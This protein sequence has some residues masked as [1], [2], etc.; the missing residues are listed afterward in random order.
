MNASGKDIYCIRLEDLAKAQ[1]EMLLPQGSIVFAG[2]YWV[3]VVLTDEERQAYPYPIEDYREGQSQG[4]RSHFGRHDGL[5]GSQPHS[6]RFLP[7]QE[8]EEMATARRKE[9]DIPRHIAVD[10]GRSAVEASECE[11]YTT[12]DGKRVP[13]GHLVRA[14]C[15][16]KRSI[17][18]EEPLPERPR[19]LFAE[20][21]V[22]VTNS[23]TLQAGLE[24]TQRGLRPLALNFANGI[25]PGGGF[26]TGS[27]AQEEVLCRSSALYKTLVGDP[28]YAAHKQ[29]P[30]PDSTDWAIYSPDVPVFRDDDGSELDHPRLLSFITS[31]APYAPRVGRQL[32]GDLLQKRIHRILSIA[33]AFGHSAMVLGAW[34]CGAF[35]CDP[36][37]TAKDF[38]QALENDF[39]GVFSDIVFAVTDWSP[40]RRFLGQF[41]DT[42][43]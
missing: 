31:A 24:M 6:L 15:A 4:P 29:R 19:P 9:L 12:Q 37:R 3:L 7:C 8:S 5:K 27:K 25:E 1:T 43:S 22:L 20:T 16:A 42:F 17:P 18:P 30:L 32:A 38:R 40:E 11:T 10:L 21:R 41:R 23:T 35:G 28:M 2:P 34:G 13:W 33:Q 14:A 39:A 26:L 36:V